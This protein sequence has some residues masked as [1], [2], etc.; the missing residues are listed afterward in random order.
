MSK[1]PR[2]A[3]ITARYIEMKNNKALILE[4]S[5]FAAM[6]LT[7]IF[8]GSLSSFENDC[9]TVRSNVFRLHVIANSDSSEDQQ[10][11]LKVRDALLLQGKEVFSS[12]STKESA[13]QA[14]CKNLQSF[15]QTAEK[16]IREN[17][18]NYSVCVS[19]GKSSFPT[20]TYENITLPAGEYDALRVVI[21]EGKG[22]NWWCVMFPPLCLPAAE[23]KQELSDVLSDGGQ[24]LVKSKPKYEIR[25]WLIEKIEQLRKKA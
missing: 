10:L 19:V 7:I 18:K 22:K 21:G 15:L 9:K 2:A 12:G 6:V 4:I 1:P 20:R 25:F 13:E 5:C 16:K 23:K 3:I 14:A 11:K 24:A 17:G 8:S